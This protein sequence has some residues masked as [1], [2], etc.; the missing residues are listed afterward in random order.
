VK[1]ALPARDMNLGIGKQ[2]FRSGHGKGGKGQDGASGRRSGRGHHEADQGGVRKPAEE[3]F[4][5]RASPQDPQRRPEQW[6]LDLLWW[7][8]VTWTVSHISSLYPCLKPSPSTW[9][10]LTAV[11]SPSTRLNEALEFPSL[12]QFS[13]TYTR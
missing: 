5:G 7:R 13:H 3:G 1:W 9:V 12:P 10:R 4:S 6:P 2:E 11:W 8:L